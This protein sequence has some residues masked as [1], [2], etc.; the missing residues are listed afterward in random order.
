MIIIILDT[1][2]QTAPSRLMP[3]EKQMSRCTVLH[4]WFVVINIVRL[5]QG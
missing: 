5:N 4:K 2:Y 3:E 1:F